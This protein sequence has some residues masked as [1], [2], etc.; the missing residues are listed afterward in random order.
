MTGSGEK[1]EV[2]LEE[3]VTGEGER[4]TGSVSGS[5]VRREGGSVA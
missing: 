2:W 4:E 1:A 5:G 3:S